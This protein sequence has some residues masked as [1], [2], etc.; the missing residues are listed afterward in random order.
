LHPGVPPHRLLDVA[1]TLGRPPLLP[2]ARLPGEDPRPGVLLLD[3][4]RGG[5]SSQFLDLLADR[6]DREGERVI[7]TL[8]LD[9][10]E[11][12]FAIG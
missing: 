3:H 7:R 4:A 12:R 10:P 9:E 1:L 11:P 8:R 2:T 5:G 6:L